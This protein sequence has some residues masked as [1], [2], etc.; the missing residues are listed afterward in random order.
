VRIIIAGPPKTGNTWLRTILAHVYDLRPLEDHERPEPGILAFQAW[1]EA[2]CFRDGAIFITHRDYSPRFVELTAA[3]PS[4]LVTILRDPYDVFVSMYY[5]LNNGFPMDESVDVLIGKALDH[6]DVLNW[7]REGGFDRRLRQ[8]QGW[9]ESGCSLIVR[10]EGMHADPMATMQAVTDEIQPA[11]NERIAAAIE[12]CRA[13]NMRQ[14]APEMPKFV[15]AARVGDSRDK[16]NAEHLAIFRDR[17]GDLIRA[18]G[19]EVL[20]PDGRTTTSQPVSRG[21]RR[22]G[23]RLD[24]D[25]AAKDSGGWNGGDPRHEVVGA[26]GQ[27]RGPKR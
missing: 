21:K 18:L 24:R 2:G 1:V 6:P 25:L 19:Y 5:Y 4:H 7:L 15:R 3:I 16:L 26:A 27:H 9:L 11:P 13:E 17:Y 22:M 12:W 20:D 23:L 8:A 14:W 10:Y